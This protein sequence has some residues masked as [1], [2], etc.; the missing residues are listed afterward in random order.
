M[1]VIDSHSR[2]RPCQCLVKRFCD[3]LELVFMNEVTNAIFSK[4]DG[5]IAMRFQDLPQDGHA[6]DTLGS[7]AREPADFFGFAA[8][9][10][11]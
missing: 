6:S 10:A 3:N 9:E 7:R 2:S 5:V 11:V 8:V 1:P 4:H